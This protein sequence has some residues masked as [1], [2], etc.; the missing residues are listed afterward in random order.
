MQF[1]DA[2][3]RATMCGTLGSLIIHSGD[4][5][6]MEQRIPEYPT[7]QRIKE[8]FEA[9]KKD[10]KAGLL[11]LIRKRREQEREDAEAENARDSHH[12]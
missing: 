12:A 4:A 5:I 2:N 8:S 7:E 9:W 6:L 1:L 10:G 11:E 3:S